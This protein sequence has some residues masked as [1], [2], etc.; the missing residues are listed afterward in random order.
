LPST[1]SS[2][3]SA[4]ALLI[5]FSGG[6]DSL[7]LLL[8]ASR[9]ARRFSFAVHAAHLD[10]RL[11]PGS[12]ARAAAAGALAE[13]LGVPFLCRRLEGGGPEKE[14]R[15]AY[16]R[17]ERYLFL[18]E[19][20]REVGARWV[21]T[22]HHADDQAETVLLRLLFG[23]GLE[24]LGGIAA[25]R[26]LSD[27]GA[28]ELLRPL[29][30]L[31]RG[32][33]RRAVALAGLEPVDDPTN[34]DLAV[35]RNR[36]RHAVLPRLAPEAGGGDELVARLGRLAAAG[37]NAA[38]KVASALTF[39]L[40]AEPTAAGARLKRNEFERLPVILHGPALSLLHR[41]AGEAQPAPAEARGELLRQL[42]RGGKVRCDCGGRRGRNF[43]WQ[44]DRYTLELCRAG[45]P[46]P[47]AAGF[48]YT[49]EASGASRR[50]KAEGS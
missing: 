23:S 46:E 37:K 15:E 14:S 27:D 11:D 38:E 3:P 32:E 33:L 16:A 9:L 45:G 2:G 43:Y 21:A 44:A 50:G 17:R 20:A 35:P 18:E 48:T 47:K 24:G 13:R 39:A 5:A 6:P 25:R 7:A 49:F 26:P 41:L 42:R 29:L 12:A 30:G 40:G 19:A 1:L 22:A 8:A 31:R 36:V 4:G 10:H 28:V 34:G